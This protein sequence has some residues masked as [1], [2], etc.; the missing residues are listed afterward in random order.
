[1]SF[2]ALRDEGK[3]SAATI[4]LLVF[5]LLFS[6]DCP[7][8]WQQFSSVPNKTKLPKQKFPFPRQGAQKANSRNGMTGV[9][10]GEAI[11]LCSGLMRKGKI[12]YDAA[13]KMSAFLGVFHH[14]LWAWD[15]ISL[16]CCL[17]IE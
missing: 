17:P 8:E 12:R 13:W 3:H 9:G 1:M 11:V 15:Q 2:S 7:V 4:M 10:G 14:L 16:C 6:S 5:L